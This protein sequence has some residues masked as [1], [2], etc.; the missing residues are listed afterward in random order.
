MFVTRRMPKNY[1]NDVYRAAGYSIITVNQNYP[2]LAEDLAKRVRDTLKLPV[3]VIQQFPDTGLDQF[4]HWHEN[5][6]AKGDSV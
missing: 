1:M 6:L 2:L 5:H 3:G 4:E